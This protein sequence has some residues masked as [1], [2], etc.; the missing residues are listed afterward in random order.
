MHPPAEHFV[1]YE[2][3]LCISAT[4]AR[5]DAADL[6]SAVVGSVHETMPGVVFRGLDQEG[7]MER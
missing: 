1:R 7:R 3:G 6:M 4:L 5:D 2:L